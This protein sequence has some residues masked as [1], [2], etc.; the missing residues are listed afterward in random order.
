MS[1]D[2]AGYGGAEDGEFAAC[3]VASA[4]RGLLEF[5]VVSSFLFPP[6]CDTLKYEVCSWYARTTHP[7]VKR[8]E[9]NSFVDACEKVKDGRSS[10]D[11]LEKKQWEEM[12]KIV[13]WV[14]ENE[15]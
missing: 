7:T 9:A 10:G 3:D 13:E 5:K 8:N 12:Q 14:L 15:K 6:T 1:C 4:R 2:C 11:E